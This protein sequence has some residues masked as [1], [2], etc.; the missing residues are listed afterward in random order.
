MKVVFLLT[1]TQS[2]IYSINA[3]VLRLKVQELEKNQSVW[4][5]VARTK[6]ATKKAIKVDIVLMI[7][8]WCYL[9]ET[10]VHKYMDSIAS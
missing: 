8:Y 1:I 9:T 3:K 10:F 6:L 2:S 5:K 4:R 7:L